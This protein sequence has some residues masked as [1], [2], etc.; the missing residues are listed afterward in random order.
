MSP[1]PTPVWARVN[2]KEGDGILIRSE[3]SFTANLVQS[4]LNGTLVEVL[5]DVINSENVTWV[6]IRTVNGKEGW[7]VRSLLATATPAP[8]W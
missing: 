6:K 1:A 7:V 5:P 2:A 8:N 3:P 4:L